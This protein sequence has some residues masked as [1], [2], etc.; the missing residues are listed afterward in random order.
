M[1]AAR[2]LFWTWCARPLFRWSPHTAY[3]F[4]RFLLRIAGA[5]L[6]NRVRCRR[7][8][9]ID[10]PWQ[11]R[12]GDLVMLSDEVVIRAA[13][14][15]EV[16]ARC[17]ISQY[18][19][20]LTEARNPEQSDHP[21]MRGPI[22]VGDDCWIATDSVVLPGSTLESGV[23]VGARGLVDGRLEAWHIATGEPARPRHRR[24][25]HGSPDTA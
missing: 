20:L 12:L 24:V 25:L 21:P 13:A 15:I 18:C 14:P 1:T 19:M 4:R 3:G 6:G 2:R 9:D 5:R 22:T 23:V 11:L 10:R 8:V 7:S 17:V 16:G